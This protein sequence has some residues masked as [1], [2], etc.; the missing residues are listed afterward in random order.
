[1]AP[2][3]RIHGEEFLLK[4]KGMNSDIVVRIA[5]E[6]IERS[7][8]KLELVNPGERGAEFRIFLEGA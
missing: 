4:E 6:A 8:G 2:P 3:R 1:M 7:G 5:K